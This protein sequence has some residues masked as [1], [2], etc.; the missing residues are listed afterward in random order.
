MQYKTIILQL[1]E[2]N[3]QIR[4]Q[5]KRDR[6]MLPTMERY[7]LELKANHEAWG[8]MLSQANPASD[9]SQITSQAMELALKDLEDHLHSEFQQ[10]DQE[11]L[12]L[13]EAMTFIRS[14]TP[15]G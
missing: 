9:Q 2:Q 11:H 7:A 10:D 5:L 4:D 15:R 6:Q 8:E 3:P 1:L 13:D 14:P 12:N